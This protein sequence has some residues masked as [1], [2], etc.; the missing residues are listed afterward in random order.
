[1]K[2]ADLTD[3]TATYEFQQGDCAG[4]ALRWSLSLDVTGDGVRDGSAWVYYG[5]TASGWTNCITG[6]AY[7]SGTNMLTLTDARWD[8]S[9][10]NAFGGTYGQT[11]AQ[12]RALFD[13]GTILHA[14]LALDGGWAQNGDQVLKAGATGTVN[15]NT[16]TWQSGGSAFVDTCALPAATI[17]VAKGD[18]VADGEINEAAVQGSL[19][20]QGSAF[21]V[22]DCKYQYVLA[23]PSLAGSGTY[24]ILIK[25]GGVSVPTPGS[26]DGKVK[27]DLK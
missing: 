25:I 15:G 5:D 17:Q 9:Q 6:A 7:Q 27:F 16:Y 26:P 3:L 19:A 11:L 23:I 18:I 21:R 12:T 2:L 14:T 8:N 13:N 10:L 1:M 22:V 24:R 4:G 20:D